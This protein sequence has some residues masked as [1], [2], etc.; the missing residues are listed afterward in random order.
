M[1]T[2]DV[3]DVNEATVTHL[4]DE[5]TYSCYVYNRRRSPDITP[6]RWKKVFGAQAE[7]M[8]MCFQMEQGA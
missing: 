1:H 2:I 8:E 4:V 3:Q 5:L 6:E 7:T